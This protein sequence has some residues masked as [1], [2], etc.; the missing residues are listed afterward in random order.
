MNARWRRG[1]E[2]VRHLQ[3]SEGFRDGDFVIIAAMDF[4]A[5]P[6]PS[7]YFGAASMSGRIASRNALSR[8]AAAAFAEGQGA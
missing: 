6:R 5:T 3:Q 2:S 1:A 4:E 8:A 7:A